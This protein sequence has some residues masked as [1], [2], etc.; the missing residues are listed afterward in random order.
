MPHYEGYDETHYC[1]TDTTSGGM[2]TLQVDRLTKEFISD[3]TGYSA[4]TGK[5]KE[6]APKEHSAL[7]TIPVEESIPIPET[8]YEVIKHSNPTA[9]T[10]K[11]LHQET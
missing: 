6:P 9:V 7:R 5:E 4:E 8:E 1:C 3:F 11:P 2:I 10:L